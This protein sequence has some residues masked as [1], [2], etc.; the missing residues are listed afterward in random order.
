MTSTNAVN[1]VLSRALFGTPPEEIQEIIK[2]DGG[3][4]IGNVLSPDE[5]S[6]INAEL[7]LVMG[8]LSGGNFGEGEENY[9]QGFM[10]ARTKRIQHCVK[11]SP[12]YRNAFLAKPLMA[13]YI[14]SILPGPA[15]THTIHASQGIEIL[16][17][18]VAQELHRDGRAMHKA[19]GTNTGKSV[20]LIA[21]TLLALTDITEEMGAT[22]VIPGSH[23]WEDLS[24][25]GTPEQTIPATMSA[26]DALLL[27]GKLVH[28]GGANTTSDRSR[29]VIS[30]AWSL[31]GIV[32]EEAWPFIL[33]VAEVATYPEPIQAALGFHSV[34]MRGEK[35]GFLWRVETQPLERYLGFEKGS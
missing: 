15:G 35:P 23:L 33:S 25:A 4:I 34:S 17:G 20:N 14:A 18:E 6:A 7:D 8:A 26:G 31:G 2:R 21:N 30:T 27:C 13:E 3:V 9:I 10:G 28:G 1:T 12:T 29:R 32:P 19:F 11:H 5:V 22:R 24:D 16:P